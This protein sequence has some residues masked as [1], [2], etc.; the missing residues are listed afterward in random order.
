MRDNSP[1]IKLFIPG[2]T[3]VLPEVLD[4]QGGWMI[5]CARSYVIPNSAKSSR[6]CSRMISF[7]I[8]SSSRLS[9]RSVN[10]SPA[11]NSSSGGPSLNWATV[12]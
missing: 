6:V 7:E 2:P 12:W 9:R 8:L 5:G 10:R 1:H 3:E 11:S 4:A